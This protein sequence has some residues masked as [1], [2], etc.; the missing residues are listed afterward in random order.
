MNAE[1]TNSFEK[2]L[3]LDA[4]PIKQPENSYNLA[5]NFVRLSDKGDYYS[6][7]N[8]KGTIVYTDLP[9]GYSVIGQNVLESD[10]ILF[11]VKN[12]LSSSQIGIVNSN[13]VYT[14]KLND[15]FNELNLDL[16]HPIDVQSRTLI[17]ES[18]I[19][20]FVDNKNPPRTVDLDNPPPIGKIDKLTTLV[21]T[22]NFPLI[23]NF[24]VNDSTTKLTCGAYQFAFRYLNSKGNI[25]NISIPS[26]LVS[27]GQNFTSAPDQYEGGYPDIIAAKSITITITNIDTDY[28]QLEIIA[29]NYQTDN[30]TLVANSVVQLDIASTSLTYEYKGDILY[31]ISIEDL[32]GLTT[33]Y[34]TAK[35]IE[36]KDGRLFISNLKDQSSVEASIQNVANNVALYYGIESVPIY[37]YKD[38]DSTA[39]KVTYKRGEVYSFAM[40]V[41]YKNGSKSFAYHIPATYVVG[42][43]DGTIVQEANTGTKLLGTYRSTLN[44]P[45]G[46]GYPQET[47]DGTTKI[48]YHAMPEFN[49]EVPFNIVDVNTG[50]VNLINIQP[51]FNVDIPTNLKNQIQG[52]YFVR[53]SRNDSLNNISIFSQGIANYMMDRFDLN[54]DTKEDAANTFSFGGLD[55][56]TY[57]L[58]QNKTISKTPFLGG[59]Q[60]VGYL[61]RLYVASPT[62]WDGGSSGGD[63]EQPIMQPWNFTFI[64]TSAESTRDAVQTTPVKAPVILDANYGATG[65]M[66]RKLLAFYSGETELLPKLE[67]NTFTKIKRVGQAVFKD[68]FN[69]RFNKSDYDSDSLKDNTQ[70]WNAYYMSSVDTSLYSTTSITV[71]KNFYVPQNS[72]IPT[73]YGVDINNAGQD[74]YLFLQVGGSGEDNTFANDEYTYKK[75]TITNPDNS[76]TTTTIDQVK[77]IYELISPNTSQYG[78]VT[79]QEYILCRFIVYD[80]ITKPPLSS[81]NNI[82]IYGGDTYITRAA[83]TNKCFI[84]SK[85]WR[86]TGGNG[87]DFATNSF[88]DAPS[89]E[90]IDLRS[91]IEFYQECFKNTDLRHAIQGGDLFFRLTDIGTSLIT[92]SFIIDSVKSYNNQYNFENNIQKFFSKPEISS[93]TTSHFKTR[94]IWSD[95]TILGEL[96]DRY[97]D[98]G[99]NNFYDIPYNTGEIWDSFVF[100]NIFYLHTPKTLW[101]TYVNS[102][103]QTASTAGQ[104]T[105]GT[106]GVFPV[107]LPPTQVINE[108]GGFGG[109]ISQWGGYNT[110]FGYIFPDSLQGKIFLLSENL[111]EISQSGLIRFMNNNLSVLDTNYSTYIDNPY[112]SGSRGILSCYDFELKRWIMTKNHEDPLKRFTISYDPIGRQFTSFHSYQ[113]NMLISRDNRLYGVMNSETDLHL[114]QHNQ[115]NYGTYY[116]NNPVPS[117]ISIIVNNGSGYSSEIGKEAG[118]G[119][120]SGKVFDDLILVANSI[121]NNKIQAYRNSG[122]TIQVYNDRQHSGV[123]NLN[124]NNTYGL[125][126]NRSSVRVQM[127]R[128]NYNIKY[129]QNALISDA[130]AIFDS[131]GNLIT[132]NIDQNKLFRDRMKGNYCVVRFDFSNNDNFQLTLN[133]IS[134][135]FREYKR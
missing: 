127:L 124:W 90:Y 87:W 113:P 21:P 72:R 64:D 108:T 110:P 118:V 112:K 129:P 18:R 9:N 67:S 39:F 40:G 134:S 105:L 25:T 78:G 53:R 28:K 43:V 119:N 4:N 95:Q 46:L 65:Q 74:G 47:G 7:T 123:T 96:R 94:T 55:F 99:T 131:N 97:R 80:Q 92:N 30:N 23:T 31:N 52:I 22:S 6:F 49:Q 109:T 120:S 63:A 103:E 104:V 29:I 88:P 32:Q 81:F 45:A 66:Y 19:V 86:F 44:Y 128:N 33:N 69:N 17:D 122:D 60:L 59:I 100:N 24:Q 84:R 56:Q 38:G 117:T 14:V 82:Q 106:G 76:D 68:Y 35:A 34:S 126:P 111:E 61:P 102:I 58:D 79:G 73:E 85:A 2:G 37:A 41:V 36:Q 91:S 8:E 115:G 27:I 20:Y 135:K 13:G 70:Y 71:N 83:Y 89:N 130:N 132:G 26:P 121:F 93:N 62:V 42:G 107:N 57:N 133:Q 16:D 3:I 15:T 51:V 54:G 125:L 11:L 50:T 12:D 10:I 101:R 75:L 114:Y 1:N 77:N 5:I 116:G 48:R 98:I